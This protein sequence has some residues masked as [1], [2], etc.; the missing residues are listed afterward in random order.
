MILEPNGWVVRNEVDPKGTFQEPGDLIILDQSRMHSV[1]WDKHFAKPTKPW[2]HLFID[3]YQRDKWA[4]TDLSEYK[5]AELAMTSI[6]S[7]QDPA[8]WNWFTTNN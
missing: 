7:I 2:I 3:I 5:A 4:K 6:E 8:H 1:C